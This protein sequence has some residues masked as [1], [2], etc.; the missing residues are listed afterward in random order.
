L[1][2]LFASTPPKTWREAILLED[3]PVLR[4]RS[5]TPV[6]TPAAS[7]PGKGT[8]AAGSDDEESDTISPAN[9]P[10]YNA[11]RTTRYLYVA[12]DDGE[13]EVYDLHADP[14]ELTN[15]ARTADPALQAAFADRLEALRI[16]R[17]GSCR[18][19]EDA[20]FPGPG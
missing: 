17:A 14:A 9:P 6:A 15:I 12:Y 8:P 10:P 5:A 18:A 4:A 19:A 3:A 20:P 1:Q 11:I 16:C 13:R 2:P 7:S